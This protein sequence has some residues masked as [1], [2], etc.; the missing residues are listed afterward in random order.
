[1]SQAD[2]RDLVGAAAAFLQ[3]RLGA[4]VV[5]GLR[6][7]LVLGSGL[8]AFAA[9][10]QAPQTVPFTEIPGFPVPR[11]EGH[12]GA[13]VVG[14]VA[15]TPVACLTGRV[16]LYEGWQPSEVVRAVRTLGALGL[17]TFLLTNAAGGIADELSAGDLM[18]LVDHLNLTGASPLVGPHRPE[19]GP[20]FPD[21]SK[22]YSPRL[23]RL[24]QQCGVA[25]RQ[26]VYAGLLG[27]SYETPAEVR[28]L[29][30][31]GAD[32]VGM[33]TVHEAMA[34]NALGAE[35]AGLSLITNLAAGIGDAPLSHDEVVAAG[36]AAA[37]T[38]THLVTEFCRRLG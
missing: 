2:E 6:V 24:L 18:L 37:A 1:M 12:G 7:G 36:T 8:K 19:F 35:V 17:R 20:R 13:L 28:M 23:R 15:G 10:I 30:R 26:G 25:L 14:R 38:L 27:P 33:S 11:V 5:A 31:L 22:V 3:Q 16:H 34:L 9:E 29:Q 21:Q 4:D 32:A